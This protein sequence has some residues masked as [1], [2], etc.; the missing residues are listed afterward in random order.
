MKDQRDTYQT[1]LLLLLLL[2][3]RD[4]LRSLL[5]RN[6]IPL[7][8]RAKNPYFT[9]TLPSNS[10]L[11]VRLLYPV[12]IYPRLLVTC[13]WLVG[14]KHTRSYVKGVSSR[15]TTQPWY[16]VKLNERW[17][18]RRIKQ[19]LLKSSHKDDHLLL[20]F[21][22]I[23]KI[24]ERTGNTNV[25]FVTKLLIYKMSVNFYDGL[26]TFCKEFVKKQNL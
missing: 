18:C 2:C 16:T 20:C 5:P 25:T 13:G 3:Q 19:L 22:C 12:K 8:Y 17:D 14:E 15:C 26:Y 23:I 21:P 24:T 1:S 11:Y 4:L 10:S 7:H 9:F 6:P